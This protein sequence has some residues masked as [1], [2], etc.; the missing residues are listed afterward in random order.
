VDEIRL[1][2]LGYLSLV[3]LGWVTLG[4]EKWLCR[5]PVMLGYYLL[6]CWYI[7]EVEMVNIDTMS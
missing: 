3:G 1:G 6:I 2:Q 5:E 7:S 4:Q